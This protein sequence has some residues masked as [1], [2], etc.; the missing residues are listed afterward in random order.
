MP[1]GIFTGVNNYGQSTCFAGAL[2]NSESTESFTWL[3][4]SF[5]ELVNN[6]APQVLLT[7]DDGAMALAFINTFEPFET[8]H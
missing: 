7:D 4:N 1:F 3:F 2:I 5:L 6:H 8:K